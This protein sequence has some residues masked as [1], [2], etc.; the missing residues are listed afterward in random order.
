MYWE[1]H[2]D[3]LNKSYSSAEFSVPYSNWVDIMKKIENSFMIKTTSQ[4]HFCNWA[5]SIKNKIEL[6][7]LGNHSFYP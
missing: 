2:I 4:Y 6:S 1:E 3:R 5:D 7:V